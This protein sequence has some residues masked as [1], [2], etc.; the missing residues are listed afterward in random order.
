[1]RQSAF[2]GQV[3]GKYY[4]AHPLLGFKVVLQVLKFPRSSIEERN[5]FLS[6]ESPF[7]L[8]NLKIQSSNPGE[9]LEHPWNPIWVNPS[10][11]HWLFCSMLEKRGKARSSECLCGQLQAVTCVYIK[12]SLYLTFW[13]RGIFYHGCWLVTRF[14]SFYLRPYVIICDIVFPLW[15]FSI[16]LL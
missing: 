16:L 9:A 3:S 5:L 2:C 8:Q 1:M 7:H 6:L 12:D 4:I 10:S 11:L 13:I 15:K 14:W